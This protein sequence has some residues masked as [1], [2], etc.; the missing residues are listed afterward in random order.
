MNDEHAAALFSRQI[1]SLF[2][3]T[4]LPPPPW[5]L[6]DPKFGPMRAMQ[7]TTSDTNAPLSPTQ[8]A[9]IYQPRLAT[10]EPPSHTTLPNLD[11][12]LPS[13]HKYVV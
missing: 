6:A 13:T 8:T 3:A 5:L 10:Q 9:T 11:S 12:T 7:S 1:W 2:L 4:T